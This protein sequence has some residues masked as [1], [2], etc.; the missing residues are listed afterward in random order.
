MVQGATEAL[1]YYVAETSFRHPDS[2]NLPKIVDEKI[3]DAAKAGFISL[4]AES[5]A[6]Y[7]QYYNRTAVDFGDSGEMGFR[8]TTE[9]IAN[10]NNGTSV[11]SDPE[12]LALTFNTGRYLL[13]QSSRPDTLPANLQGIWN[14]DFVPP[15]G[16][17]FTLD[18]NLEMNYWMTYPQNLPE[19]LS[20][21]HEF[22]GR[23]HERGTRVAQDMY[24]ASGWCC[25]H[26][27]DITADCAPYHQSTLWSPSAMSGAWM[28]FELVEHWRFSKDTTWAATVA[29]PILRDAVAF[30]R[31]FCIMR[32]GYWVTTPTC[33]PENA[34]VVPQDMTSAGNITGLDT[35]P[36]IDRGIMWEIISGFLDISRAIGATE[37]TEEAAEF[38]SKVQGPVVGTWGQV[39]E[40]S[41]EFVETSPG[42]RHFSPLL[43]VFPGTWVSPVNNK[44]AADA[45]D[46]LLQYRMNNGAGGGDSWS[47]AWATAL[48]ARLFHGAAALTTAIRFVGSWVFDAMLS[49]NGSYFQIDGNC[50]IVAA[51]TEMLLQSQAGFIHLGP[52]LP[53]H[54]LL[55]GR[56]RGFK[57]RGGFLVDMS[58]KDGNVV[59]ATVTSLNGSSLAL[60][61]QDAL[62]FTVNGTLYTRPLSTKP[63][64]VFLIA[65]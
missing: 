42:M 20:P 39:L 63:G 12:M 15:W 52:A 48:Y 58:W 59:E 36:M 44:T 57:A 54:G 11:A 25:H 65:V 53:P 28:S 10:Y 37:G 40:W 7:Q 18:I 21:V 43:P 16:C 31:T 38:L 62:E 32:D 1:V 19:I 26:D 50:G 49:R 30:F 64:D 51:L 22:L 27:T 46:V 35:G 8:S 47:V 13:I 56:F 24:G 45:S 3:G 6:D 41:Q 23:L 61:V 4:S 60:R 17:K 33:S 5:V 34:Y 29:Y 14:K 55:T 9:R 2:S